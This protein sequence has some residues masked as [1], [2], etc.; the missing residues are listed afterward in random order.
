M[1][2]SDRAGNVDLYVMD[3]DGG[4][5]T[6]LTD[7]PLGELMADW[8]PDGA[9]IVYTG[10]AGDRP[11]GAVC[12][13]RRRKRKAPGYNGRRPED[14]PPLGR[15]PAFIPSAPANASIAFASGRS[16]Q[17]DVY[18]I[19]PSG[20]HAFRL[21]R[22]PARDESPAWSPKGGRIAFQSF[23]D[24]NGEVYVMDAAGVGQRNLTDNPALD[25][26]P[27]W[28]PDGA[29]IA[30][31]TDRDGNREVYAMASDG[32][33]PVNLTNHD[34]DDYA[35]AW[36]PDGSRI[37][38]ATERYGSLELAV[39]DADGSN[40]TRL[41]SSNASSPPAGLVAQRRRAGL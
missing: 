40:V 14:L 34:G 27:A 28:S 2:H 20:N 17:T 12:D 26:S 32:G 33:K 13:E 3:A 22:D 15:A 35:P 9:K 11:A 19:E 5:L 23:R 1:F 31:D 41:T 8:S 29:R 37:T 7:G 18:R 30:F 10:R 36:S 24:G 6:P 39:M 25:G 16:G 38:F 21:T 4:N